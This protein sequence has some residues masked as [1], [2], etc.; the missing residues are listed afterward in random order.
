MRVSDWLFLICR[1]RLLADFYPLSYTID[2]MYRVH[3]STEG[4][5]FQMSVSKRSHDVSKSQCGTSQ[6]RPN[7][8]IRKRAQWW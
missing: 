7:C 4:A 3:D 8:P 2:C 5:L 6:F 1:S